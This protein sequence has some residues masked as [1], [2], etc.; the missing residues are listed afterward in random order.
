LYRR[1]WYSAAYY[2]RAKVPDSQEKIP[3]GRP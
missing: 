2:F 3:H 1:E